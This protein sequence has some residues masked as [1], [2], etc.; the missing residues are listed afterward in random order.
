M[1]I[2]AISDIHGCY[3]TFQHMLEE[4]IELQKEDILVLCGDFIDRGPDT[5]GLI[6]YILQLQQEGF[7]I[8][9]LKGNH[10]AMMLK[11]LDNPTERA[12]TWLFNGG[13][14]TLASYGCSHPEEFPKDHLDFFRNLKLHTQ[15]DAYIFVHAGVGVGRIPPLDDEKALLCKK[16]VWRPRLHMAG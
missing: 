11:S 10:E 2:L 1:R 8:E 14:E 5:R 12:T 3:R 4:V 6:R 15:V 7:Q 9:C 16:L 13:R